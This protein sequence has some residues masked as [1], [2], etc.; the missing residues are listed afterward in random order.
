MPFLCPLCCDSY[1]IVASLCDECKKAKHA[2]S[3]Y[4]KEKVLDVIQKVLVRN[5]KQIENK[6]AIYNKN[7]SE[8]EKKNGKWVKK[9]KSGSSIDLYNNAN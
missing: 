9:S 1:V 6:C 7:E 5:D 3:L 2:M 4:G 8:Y